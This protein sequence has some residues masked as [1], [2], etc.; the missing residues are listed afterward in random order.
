MSTLTQPRTINYFNG[1]VK[2]Q[3]DGEDPFRVHEKREVREDAPGQ[4][5]LVGEDEAF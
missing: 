4:F 5:R 2:R 1:R 3:E